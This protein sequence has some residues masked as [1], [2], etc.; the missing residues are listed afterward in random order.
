MCINF[1][2]SEKLIPYT[3]YQWNVGSAWQS[4]YF[5]KFNLTAGYNQVCVA[6]KDTTKTAFR[7][8]HEAY[9]SIAMSFGMSNAPQPF[10]PS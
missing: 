7:T 2:K 10:K 1:H 9:E 6:E 5:L 8:K 3:S 4:Y